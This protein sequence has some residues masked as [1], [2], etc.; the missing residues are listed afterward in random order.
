MLW[1]K[2]MSR[3]CQCHRCNRGFYVDSSFRGTVYCPWCGND[4]GDILDASNKRYS[5]TL[6]LVLFF[7]FFGA[8][9]YYVG[10]Y[11]SAV[12]YTF[13]AGFFLIGWITDIP[14]V[15]FKLF[16][17]RYGDLVCRG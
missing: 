7:G 12:L 1:S 8:H 9:R 2:F 10:R 5:I 11:G 17:D 13:T 3:S 14:K 16:V 6:L 15:L 4:C